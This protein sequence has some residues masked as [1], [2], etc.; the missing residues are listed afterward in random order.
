[1]FLHADVTV[2]VDQVS[3]NISVTEGD[4]ASLCARILGTADFPISAY[5]LPH[6][7]NDSAVG[8]VDFETAE[9]LLSFP[10]HSTGLQCVDLPTVEDSVVERGEELWAELVLPEQASPEV[11]LGSSV[12]SLTI[13]DDDCESSLLFLVT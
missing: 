1:M 8:G 4:A 6:A 13:L 5:F 10:A 9:R 7:I 12:V 2:L 3:S 11:A